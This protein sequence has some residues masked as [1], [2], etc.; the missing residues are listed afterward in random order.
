[1][2]LPMK[3]YLALAAGLLTLCMVM[4][5]TACAED[6]GWGAGMGGVQL[7]QDGAPSVPAGT[8]P[9]GSGSVDYVPQGPF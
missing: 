6:S 4:F 3:G 7:Q 5:L 8:S 1:M 9:P 2:V